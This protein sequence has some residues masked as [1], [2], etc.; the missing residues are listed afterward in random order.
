MFSLPR[1][2][3]LRPP[4]SVLPFRRPPLFLPLHCSPLLLPSRP[5][6]PPPA[7]TSRPSWPGSRATARPGQS[8]L[9]LRAPPA[10]VR[11]RRGLRVGTG[12]RKPTPVLPC[13][14][15]PP[16]PRDPARDPC[17]PLSG[18][19]GDLRRQDTARRRTK[20][21]AR[22]TE[23]RRELESRPGGVARGRDAASSRGDRAAFLDTCSGSRDRQCSPE[24]VGRSLRD[25]PRELLAEDRPSRGAD[26]FRHHG[27]ADSM[28]WRRSTDEVPRYSPP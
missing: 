12:C 4:S 13:I 3:Q 10:A 8:G 16:P 5:T 18:S 2:R 15:H 26:L 27:G 17:L 24:P 23:L 6:H 21:E 22:E 7:P 1:R 9:L 20:D 14:A 19:L 28:N 11:S 25:T